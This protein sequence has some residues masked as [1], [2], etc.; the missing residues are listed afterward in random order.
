MDSECD[1]G[2]LRKGGLSEGSLRPAW[3]WTLVTRSQVNLIACLFASQMFGSGDIPQGCYQKIPAEKEDG[4][5]LKRGYS[6]SAQS[7]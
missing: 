2:I 4:D 5:D 3:S 7:K 1:L 6:K